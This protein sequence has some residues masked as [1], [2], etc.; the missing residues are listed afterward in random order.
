MHPNALPQSSVMAGAI[1]HRDTDTDHNQ[2]P[3]GISYFSD[4]ELRGWCITHRANCWQRTVVRKFDGLA[5]L[6]QPKAQRAV[7]I[8]HAAIIA[9]ESRYSRREPVRCSCSKVALIHRIGRRFTSDPGSHPCS[10][11]SS[12][13]SCPSPRTTAGNTTP[14][15]SRRRPA[16]DDNLL[17]AGKF[18][19]RAASA[20]RAP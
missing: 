13:V 16:R 6:V 3:A 10:K 15:R 11:Y 1:T 20:S 19:D 4:V 17:P 14:S 18:P 2:Q 9:S 12:P 5:I 8:I 7:H